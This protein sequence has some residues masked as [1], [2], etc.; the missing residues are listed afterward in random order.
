[1]ERKG[2][3]LGMD[4]FPCIIQGVSEVRKHERGREE[5]GVS[6]VRSREVE[7]ERRRKQGKMWSRN[8]EEPGEEKEEGEK[9]EKEVMDMEERRRRRKKTG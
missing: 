9:E 8:E 5:N 6:R 2:G 3:G 1:M 4:S 7:E